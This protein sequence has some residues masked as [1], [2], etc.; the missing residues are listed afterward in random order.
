MYMGQRLHKVCICDTA[1]ILDDSNRAVATFS[2]I[3]SRVISFHLA[4]EKPDIC[5]QRHTREA[6]K[7][8][9]PLSYI[10]QRDLTCH[11]LSQLLESCPKKGIL[12]SFLALLLC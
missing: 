9:P 11:S 7:H 10:P 3:N 4:G 1:F 8:V 5:G 6:Q 2:E 12:Y